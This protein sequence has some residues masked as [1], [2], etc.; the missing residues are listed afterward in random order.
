M[1]CTAILV[2]NFKGRD[3][4]TL[5]MFSSRFEPGN[6]KRTKA[7]QKVRRHSAPQLT[8]DAYNVAD[9]TRR[10][11]TRNPASSSQKEFRTSEAFFQ[12]TECECQFDFQ[13]NAKRAP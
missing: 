13:L 10:G 3:V 1:H 6:R 2:C 8:E 9:R 12:H 7:Y 11:A 4:A 5:R